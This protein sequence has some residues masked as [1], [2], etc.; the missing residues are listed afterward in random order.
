MQP[1][2]ILFDFAET[3]FEDRSDFWA[4]VFFYVVVLGT[5]PRLVLLYTLV[6]SDTELVPDLGILFLVIN[7]FADNVFCKVNNFNGFFGGFI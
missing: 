4:T 7:T 2:P 6:K 3:D 1:N 5:N